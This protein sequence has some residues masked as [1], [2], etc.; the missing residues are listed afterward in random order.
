MG[1]CR[2]CGGW[3]GGDAVEKTSCTATAFGAEDWLG[4]SLALA[5]V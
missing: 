5:C 3:V 1:V 4:T 2:V